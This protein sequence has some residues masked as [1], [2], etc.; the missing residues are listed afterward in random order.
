M[1]LRRWILLGCK[2][3]KMLNGVKEWNRLSVPYVCRVRKCVAIASAKVSNEISETLPGTNP[4][5]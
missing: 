5:Q 3:I 1:I 2:G 4:Y